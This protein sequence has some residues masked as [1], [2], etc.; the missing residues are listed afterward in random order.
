MPDK[1]TPDA[2]PVPDKPEMPST[3]PTDFPEIPKPQK[4]DTPF[5]PH[6]EPA[7]GKPEPD[8]PGGANVT[9]D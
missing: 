7:P 5:P 9:A 1:P 2:I 6:S 3:P 8:A 4:P